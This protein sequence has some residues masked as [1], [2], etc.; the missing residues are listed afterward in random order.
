MLSLNSR[1]QKGRRTLKFSIAMVSLAL[2]VTSCGS[3]PDEGTPGAG[4]QTVRGGNSGS[5]GR[6]GTSGGS[7]TGGS[8][9]GSTTGGSSGGSTT[10]GTSGGGTG[11]S[12]GSPAGGAGGGSGGGSGGSVGGSPDS[13]AGGA[14]GGMGGGMPP[15]SMGGFGSPCTGMPA[16]AA[17]ALKK[18]MITTLPGGVQAGQ[19]V[20][21]PGEGSRIYVV[22]HKDGNIYV[23][24][25]GMRTV[26]AGAKV[27]VATGGNNEQGLL[28]MAF[29]PQK[30]NTFYLFYT[31][32]G[33]GRITVDEFERTSPTA[34]TKKGNLHNH[35]GS[36]RFHNGGSIYFS[37]K[38]S[39][40]LLYLSVG[41]AQ[42]PGN[43]SP[44]EG[45]NG[46]ILKIDTASKMATT[47]HFNLRNPY[48][49]SIDRLTG[50]FWIGNVAGPQGGQIHYAAQG[51]AP[52]NWGHDSTTNAING[53]RDSSGNAIIGGV[54]YRGNKIAG[55]CGR[56]FFGQHNTGLVKSLI[57]SGGMRT[58][59]VASHATLNSGGLSSFGEDGEGEMYISTLGGAVFKVEA[60]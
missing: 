57:Q 29:H 20:G 37:P 43:A 17:P 38:D 31:A 48:R 1:P 35:A 4:G 47:A 53:G 30:P 16:A 50:D 44:P 10:G 45:T 40:P 19:V 60:Q 9:G 54:V 13:G 18:T 22:G 26:M 33:S 36:N 5:G 42:V 28:S 34:A 27:E 58:G 12:G 11:G 14:Q 39:S 23:V 2:A 21:V 8:S 3:E 6:G 59:E 32:A 15:M 51:R 49:M 56:Y 52:T 46:R 41:D 25:N 7:T 55:L 24:E